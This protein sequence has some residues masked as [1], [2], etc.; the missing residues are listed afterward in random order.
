VA[1]IFR[2]FLIKLNQLVS[3]TYIITILLRRWC[4]SNRHFWELAGHRGG[5]TADI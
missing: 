4:H 3:E 2:I 5:K 1:K